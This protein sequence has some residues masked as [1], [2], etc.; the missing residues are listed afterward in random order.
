MGVVSLAHTSYAKADRLI[1]RRHAVP[2]ISNLNNGPTDP[3]DTWRWKDDSRK[4]S[5]VNSL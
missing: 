5:G 1:V 2:R 4:V 3:E